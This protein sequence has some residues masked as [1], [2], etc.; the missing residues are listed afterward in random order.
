MAIYYYPNPSSQPSTVL[1]LY[2]ASDYFVN[3]NSILVIGTNPITGLKVWSKYSSTSTIVPTTAPALVTTVLNATKTLTVG[4][5]S[6]Y[7]IGSVYGGA[8]V[9]TSYTA[10][11]GTF[12]GYTV[13][14]T[15]ALPSGLTLGQTFST[16]TVKDVNG[17]NNLYNSILFK[18]SGT[19]S[20]QSAS[21][22][23]TIQ[24]ADSS[25]K[26]ITLT[27]NL[28]VQQTP[29]ALTSTVNTPN[30][31]ITVNSAVSSS[32]PVT[33][34]GLSSYQVITPFIPVTAT[35]GVGTLTYSISPSLPTGLSLNTSTGQISG[36]PTALLSST[37]Y[38]V[39]ARDQTNATTTGSFYLS[40]I[41][42][43]PPVL[44]AT[45]N[46]PTVALIKDQVNSFI[47]VVGSGGQGT[48]TYSIAP[49]SLPSGI[50]YN[51][52]T[53][54]LSGTP[55][56]LLSSVTPFVVTISD[57]VPQYKTASFILTVS[58]APVDNTARSTACTAS[59]T[60]C[61]A[62]STAC[63]ASS[64]ACTAL[65]TAC[66]A[67]STACTA[68]STACT[69]L[70]TA[71][72]ALSTACTAISTACT[73]IS[74]A[75]T[76][77]STA[78]TALSTACTATST[79]CTAS[80][81]AGYGWNHANA[82]YAQA[83]SSYA[84]AN[85]AFAQA[86]T[87]SSQ[88]PQANAAYAQA[89]A[90][91]NTANT[92]YN[93]SGGTITGN[94]AI[95]NTL[96]S[97]SCTT[98]AL[99]VSGGVGIAK[100]LYVGGD[101]KITNNII[102]YGSNSFFYGNVVV[103]GNLGIQGTTFTISSNNVSYVDS[104]IE[105]HNTANS[106]PL[107]ID[108]GKDIGIRAH[109]YK[110]ADKQA[111]FGW[112]NDSGEFEYF[113]DGTETNGE[114]SGTYGTIKASKF[115][116]M[117]TTDAPFIINSTTQVANLNSQYAGTVTVAAQPTITSVGTLTS[118]TVSGIIRPSVGSGQNGIIFPTD[119]FGG[120]GDVASIK[121]YANTGE[122]GILEIQALNDADDNIQL[123]ASGNVSVTGAR[124]STDKSSGAFVVNGGV[125]IAKNVNIGGATTVN[126]VT[127]IVNST[128]SSSSG[129]GALT[130]AGGVGIAKNLYVDG[131]IRPNDGT[132]YGIQ[133]RPDPGG[134]GSDTA[135][136]RY[137]PISGE[138]CVLD[139]TVTND[140][141]DMINLNS[142]GPVNVINSGDSSSSGSG[143]LVVSGGVGIAKT[144]NVGNNL[145]VGGTATV[146][147]TQS[148]T[149]T[150][151]STST[152]SGALV[153]SGGLGVSK[154]LNV[155]SNTNFSGFVNVSNSI[156]VSANAAVTGNLTVS[157]NTKFYS[158][159][160]L[161]DTTDST[162]KTTGS[163]IVD[164]G[165]GVSKNLNAGLSVTANAVYANAYYYANGTPFVGG[166][167]GT[168]GGATNA[169]S[170]LQVTGQSTLT[171]NSNTAALTIASGPGITLSS[172]TIS[173][174]L[175]IS[176]T[177]YPYSP[178]KLNQLFNANGSNTTFGLSDYASATDLLVTIDGIIQTPTTNYTVSGLNLTFDTAPP[179][180]AVIEVRTFGNYVNQQGFTN[181]FTASGFTSTFTLS[182]TPISANSIMVSVNGAIKTP[183]T[184]FTLS[185]TTLSFNS[186]PA[187]NSVI[188]VQS[189]NNTL[190]T[191][192][193]FDSFGATSIYSNSP[194]INF[195][196]QSYPIDTFPVTTYR[197]AKYIISVTGN[198]NSSFQATEAL[199][200]H[201][202]VTP[203]LVTYGT[204]Y[205]GL[206][207]IITFSA[208]IASGTVTL[209]GIGSVANNN[210][211]LQKTYVPV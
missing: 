184:D 186:T 11:S 89:N 128:D 8:A 100:D 146:S 156:I 106:D 6:S 62:L 24:V 83:N 149:N 25:G 155:G 41:S 202:G 51:T 5:S 93:I 206:T 88:T 101:A 98:G 153:V 117:T 84:Q 85:A 16:T 50:T 139:L 114:F 38:T 45:V 174:T 163:L 205:T 201:D 99:V 115:R 23:Y 1:S 15:P 204:V 39:T 27:F 142:S 19:P 35:N 189:F 131:V 90:A 145:N 68:L 60:A 199:L 33:T 132:S 136:I 185:G 73:A 123:T 82:A 118:L 80:A 195:N 78:C 173:N 198:N 197:S 7:D 176:A 141:E 20:A 121:Y 111:F 65:S 29:T 107:T 40:I 211:K 48:L 87:S 32:T 178:A 17:V 200:V 129:T 26:I 150:T 64:T 13:S 151:D 207:P 196:A 95:S 86:N 14:V 67:I 152:S 72:T 113:S 42:T 57:T 158:N 171:A 193:S 154:T 157:G 124:E 122:A 188:T 116:S 9:A 127:T 162:S 137:Y 103:T 192:A 30:K 109:Y 2:T 3:G 134:G 76:A 47:P 22:A 102:V 97:T 12:V 43:V 140:Y 194:N 170:V 164:G 119:P 203:Q 49:S 182:G 181:Q 75:C 74:T 71:C 125:G 79:A 94:V 144:L 110:G 36:T 179:A 105:L 96:N 81:T 180:G 210:V 58:D 44:I 108:D 159:V 183:F 209:Y 59:S 172:S 135:S 175:T 92:K 191:A 37:Q 148:V 70:S 53:G 77:I 133:F 4:Q 31:I 66:T 169:F 177:S 187:L 208:S 55:T 147:G 61:T 165:L 34:T 126:G 104:I 130:V 168:V 28:T 138:Q 160:H 63:T 18:L 112:A 46:Y 91:F 69:A 167:G 120:S 21:T 56:A 10:S 190:G 143:A 54:T 161:Y 166:S 52:S